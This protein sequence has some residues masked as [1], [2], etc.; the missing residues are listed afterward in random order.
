MRRDKLHAWL[1]TNCPAYKGLSADQQARLIDESLAEEREQVRRD[2]RE[3]LLMLV[4]VF[5]AGLLLSPFTGQTPLGALLFG[6]LMIGAAGVSQYRVASRIEL[7]VR[8]AANERATK[9]V[10][11]RTERI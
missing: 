10:S 7:R 6:L 5:G 2:R 4:V 11:S 3:Q 8:Q 1:L 9:L